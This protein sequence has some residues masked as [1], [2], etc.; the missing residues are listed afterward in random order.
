MSL[1]KSMTQTLSA[2]AI[3]ESGVTIPQTAEQSL[4]ED[5]ASS[6]NSMARL[7]EDEMRFTPEMVVVRQSN[8]LGRYLIEMEDISRY[9]MTNGLTSIREAISDILKV[10]DLSG[11]YAD[12]AIVIDEQS[13]MEEIEPLGYAVSGVLTTPPKGLGLG[14]ISKDQDDFKKF[15]RIANTK[16]LMDV[17][18]GRYG[19]TLVKKNYKQEGLLEASKKASDEDV[20]IKPKDDDQEVIHEKD[21]KKSKPKKTCADTCD[22][23]ECECNKDHDKDCEDGECDLDKTMNM[24]PHQLKIQRI[25]DIAAGKYD[26]DWM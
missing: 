4:L 15:R 19:L 24:D 23:P 22:D 20:E 2:L 7:N 1:F 9:M 16:Q 21:D 13:I 25:K 10:N 11:H 17:L 5:V 18:T 6:L 8:R 12:V 26:D 3:Q 14:M